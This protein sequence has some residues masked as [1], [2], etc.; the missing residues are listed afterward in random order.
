MLAGI[1]IWLLCITENQSFLD[2][3]A[4]TRVTFIVKQG[5]KMT[6]SPVGCPYMTDGGTNVG[7]DVDT[8]VDWYPF[9]V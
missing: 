8:D 9:Q 3:S 2:R 4:F 5:Q 6:K 7:I 1:L